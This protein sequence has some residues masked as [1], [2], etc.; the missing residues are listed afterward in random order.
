MGPAE[1]VQLI[2]PHLYAT[3][4]LRLA[5]NFGMVKCL[6]PYRFTKNFFSELPFSFLSI[7]MEPQAKAYGSSKCFEE[8]N[9]AKHITTVLKAVP[10]R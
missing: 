8:R 9:S 1:Q 4:G 2:Q 10:A 6:Y 3:T 5:Q 7:S